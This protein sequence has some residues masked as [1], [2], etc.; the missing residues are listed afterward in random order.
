MRSAVVGVASLACLVA[1]ASVTMSS[2]AKAQ[3][4]AAQKQPATQK[5]QPGVRPGAE[6]AGKSTPQASTP[7]LSTRDADEKLVRQIA[8]NFEKAYNAHDAKALSALF[9]ADAEIVSEFGTVTQGRADIGKAFASIFDDYPETKISV[10]IKSI[11]MVSPGVAIEDGTTTTIND[12]GEAE[13][14]SRYTVVHVRQDGK[15]LMASARDLSEE[16]S[17]ESLAQLEW[18]VGDWVDESP[19]G[20]VT[21]LTRWT[22]N[23]R[24]LLSE[25]TI[26]VAGRPV[27]NGTQRIG[28]DPLAKVIR[29]WV[30]DSEGGFV[31]GVYSRSGNQW[32]AK[33]TGVTSDG[34]PALATNV[35]T[36]V[37]RDRMTWESRDRAIGGETQADVEPV[38]VVRKPPKPM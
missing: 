20:L 16:A 17:E 13:E 33:M 7:A 9:T 2:K 34:Q 29:S 8:E 12:P 22:D 19:D 35:I 32:M 36:L 3:K 28:W 30:F 15:W 38:M 31:E 10:A 21:T 1:V 14:L 5:A 24:F 6:K 23:H 27:M 26:Q 25:F 18:M 37:S 4:A 11:R